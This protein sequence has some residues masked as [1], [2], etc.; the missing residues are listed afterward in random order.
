MR[1][2]AHSDI[3]PFA[4]D[5]YGGLDPDGSAFD[6]G[7]SPDE[8]IG[9]PLRRR[10]RRTLWT[11]VFLLTAF[12]GAWGVYGPPSTWPVQR[13]ADY[14]GAKGSG[15]AGALQRKLAEFNRPAP[16]TAV[17][18]LPP[19]EEAKPIVSDRQLPPAPE[20]MPAVKDQ[21]PVSPIVTGSLP[22]AAA[23][24]P[25]EPLPPPTVD[26][27]DPYQVK[28]EAVGLHPGLSRVLLTRLSE[29]DYRNAGIAIK[30]ALA[31]TPPD[32][33]YLYPHERK[34]GLALFKVHFVQGAGSD[35]RRYV[36][37]ITKDGWATT[38]FPME[39]CG[40]QYRRRFPV[41]RHQGG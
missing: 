18:Q 6:G 41:A 29:T 3:R 27:S 28:A 17:S 26:R 37:T 13:W 4:Y 32:G 39:K 36:V 22:P 25:V 33:V 16:P 7:L 38:A 24:G 30:T 19:I 34:H 8:R 12:G 15:L 2:S 40:A 35:C 10:G 9:R 11:I 21:P 5:A 20:P 1:A 31:E 23:N 14:A